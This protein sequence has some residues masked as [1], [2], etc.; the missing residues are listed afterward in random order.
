MRDHV[1]VLLSRKIQ[2]GELVPGDKLSELAVCSELGISRTPAREA[3]LQLASEGVLEYISRRGFRIKNF[4][5]AEKLE[6]YAVIEILD[7]LAAKLAVEYINDGCITSMMECADMIDVTIKYKNY[8]DYYHLQR[9]FHDTY[10]DICGNS[11]LQKQLRD[12][13]DSFVPHLYAKTPDDRLFKAFSESNS[14]HRRIINLFQERNAQGLFDFIMNVHWSTK[15]KE[16][17]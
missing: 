2:S 14:E 11:V 12:L 16:M 15:Y 8:H 9:K 3:L 7:A 13:L 1:R 6:V 4:P 5:E 10:R 17:I